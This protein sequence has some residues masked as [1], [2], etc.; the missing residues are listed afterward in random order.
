[1]SASIVTLIVQGTLALLVFSSALAWAIVIVKGIQLARFS[2]E[3]QRFR[4]AFPARTSLPRREEVAAARGPVA[5]LAL[6]GL[7]AW[8]TDHARDELDVHKDVL[9]RSLSQQIRNERRTLDT[10][11]TLLASIGT[12]AP[13]VGL[14]GTVF[15][16]IDALGSIAASGSAS[17][18]VVAGPIGEALIATGVGI[19]VAV[20]AVLAYNYFGRRV[21]SIV[22]DLDDYASSL[23]NTAL[24]STLSAR[25]TPKRAS[26]PIEEDAL[27][28]ATHGAL[29]GQEART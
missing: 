4:A 13:F 7:D 21:K 3:D 24:R 6:V 20:P 27:P 9:E 8:G 5:R 29:V 22:A 28:V 2:R 18:D 26:A 25:S 14:F 16:I 10:G 1:M 17:L 23:V 12:T 15:G 19:A 11:L